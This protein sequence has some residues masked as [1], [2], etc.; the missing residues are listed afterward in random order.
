MTTKNHFH[1]AALASALLAVAPLTADA[2]LLSGLLNGGAQ[3]PVEEQADNRTIPQRYI[4]TVDSSLSSILDVGGPLLAGIE[5]LLNA[6][7]GGKVLYLYENVM[8]GATVQLTDSQARMLESLPGVERVEPDS[9][10]TASGTLI[11]QNATWGLDRVD[12]ATL[13]L[14]SQ[15]TYPELAGQGV[16]VY[17]LDTG[18][19]STHA[20]FEGRASGMNFHDDSGL[21]GLSPGLPI[22]GDLLNLLLGGLLP[23]ES[24]ESISTY[25]AEDCN[26]HG[27]H[28][29]STAAGEEFGVAKES[30]IIGL[31]VLGCN[32]SGATSAI[33]EALDWMAEN[34]EKPAVA[35]MSLGGGSSQTLDEAVQAVV[36]RGIPVVVAAGNSNADACSGSPNRVPEAVTVGATDNRDRRSSFSNHGSCVDIMAPGTDITAAWY[37]GDTDTNTISGTSMASPHVAGAVALMLGQ[38]PSLSPEQ[39]DQALKAQAS[40][41]QLQD[42]NGSPNRLLNVNP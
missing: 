39:V 5:Q 32:G 29:A 37:T 19:L 40:T 42:L 38:N 17:V 2:G 7:G 3:E 27:T 28:V 14:D 25:S 34:A 8:S 24:E 35:N 6:V 21:A 26:G 11:Q 12:Q 23:F 16:N 31:R 22:V 33:I 36:A 15:F 9:W 4:V 41:N 13:P 20:D 30:N 1:K 18:V 10:M